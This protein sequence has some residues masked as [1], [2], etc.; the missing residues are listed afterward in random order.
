MTVIRYSSIGEVTRLF[1]N[2]TYLQVKNIFISS[3]VFQHISPE[4]SQSLSIF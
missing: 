1:S 2:Q 4:T 3:I